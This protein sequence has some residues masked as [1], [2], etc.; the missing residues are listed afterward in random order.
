MGAAAMTQLHIALHHVHDIAA[1]HQFCDNRAGS[2]AAPFRYLLRRAGAIALIF[3][4]F[5]AM[6]RVR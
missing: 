4:V 2:L 3:H 1:L 6:T 5:A